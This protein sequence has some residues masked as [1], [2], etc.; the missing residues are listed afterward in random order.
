[1]YDAKGQINVSLF[2]T[3]PHGFGDGI[4]G[5][6]IRARWTGAGGMYFLQEREAL[7][8]RIHLLTCHDEK[9]NEWE[10]NRKVPP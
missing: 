3:E 6:C 7:G 9:Y 1:M 10:I 2:P 5:V 4:E 8:Q